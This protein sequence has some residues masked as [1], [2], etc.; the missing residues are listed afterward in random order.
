MTLNAFMHHVKVVGIKG[1]PVTKIELL[2]LGISKVN[3][4]LICAL[5]KFYRVYKI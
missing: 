5:F 3:E 2:C 4:C 1:V